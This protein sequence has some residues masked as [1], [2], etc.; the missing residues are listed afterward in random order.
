MH[1]FDGDG[2]AEKAVGALGEPDIAH[3][4]TSDAAGEAVGSDRL[5]GAYGD[6]IGSAGNAAHAL[7]LLRD[8]T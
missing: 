6:L 8:I 5:P 1:Q 4:A 3:A 7:V 2:T